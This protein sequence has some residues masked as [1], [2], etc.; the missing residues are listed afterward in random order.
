MFFHNKIQEN[1]K[2]CRFCVN[3]RLI[4]DDNKVLCVRNGIVKSNF[5]CRKFIYDYLKHD[6]G[7]EP[8]IQKAEFVDIN[9]D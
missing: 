7:K 6:P 9:G 2:M 4:A 1:E 8:K 5:T 3:S